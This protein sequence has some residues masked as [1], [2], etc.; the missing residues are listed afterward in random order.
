MQNLWSVNPTSQCGFWLSGEGLS[1]IAPTDSSWPGAVPV[2]SGFWVGQIV[3][4][5][6]QVRAIEDELLESL[7]LQGLD[8]KPQIVVVSTTFQLIILMGYPHYV[9]CLVVM[10]RIRYV[11]ICKKNLSMKW[12]A[13]LIVWGF[14]CGWI[15]AADPSY[16][17]FTRNH[18]QSADRKDCW[19]P[20]L[21]YP[22][23]PIPSQ[24]HHS[25]EVDF[26]I[27]CLP[28]L[29]NICWGE[30]FTFKTKIISP[31]I[32]LCLLKCFS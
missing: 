31:S 3:Y 17:K 11:C 18:V 12:I 10:W 21:P 2:T 14:M 7:Q 23:N 20:A 25:Q 15:F 26:T 9:F 5:L 13:R 1:W 16:S 22:T 30:H 19:N 27:W 24:W 28:L 32:R 4:I 29:G 8:I 6:D